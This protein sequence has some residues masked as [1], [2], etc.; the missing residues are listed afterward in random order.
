M[1]AKA[2]RN[3]GYYSTKYQWGQIAG[4]PGTAF[5]SFPSWVA[6][7]NGLKQAIAHCGSS[8][9]FT[10]GPVQ[11]TQYHANGLDADYRC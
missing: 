3:V 1:T 8:Y 10:G 7:S 2:I 4:D 6:G 11:L 9:S 5:A